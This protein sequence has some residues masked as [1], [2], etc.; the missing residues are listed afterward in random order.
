MHILVLHLVLLEQVI[1]DPSHKC[2]YVFANC[3]D[4]MMPL[5]LNEEMDHT[6]KKKNSR[7]GFR[8]RTCSR[9]LLI[10]AYDQ[11]YAGCS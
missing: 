3:R 5:Y 1:N 9:Y 10:C 8:E 6:Q 4:S 11:I 2:F 7:T